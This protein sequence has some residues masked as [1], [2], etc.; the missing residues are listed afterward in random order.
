MIQAYYFV[1]SNSSGLLD[2]QREDD[3]LNEIAWNDLSVIVQILCR[4]KQGNPKYVIDLR[5]R[6][7]VPFISL[8]HATRSLTIKPLWLHGLIKMRR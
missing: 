6:W 2:G 7:K 3:L 4:E 8:C 5:S 1:S